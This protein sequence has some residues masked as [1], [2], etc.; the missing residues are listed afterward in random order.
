MA[1]GHSVLPGPRSWSA[2]EVKVSLVSQKRAKA[3]IEPTQGISFHLHLEVTTN[4]HCYI[5]FNVLIFFNFLF[6]TVI[7]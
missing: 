3:R 7:F 5:I 6:G 1:Y 2:V 4:F